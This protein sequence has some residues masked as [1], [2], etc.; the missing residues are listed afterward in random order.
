MKYDLSPA[1][2]KVVAANLHGYSGSDIVSVC[3]SAAIQPL[4]QAIEDHFDSELHTDETDVVDQL[5]T[6]DVRYRFSIV[7]CFDLFL[8][9]LS[10]VSN[11]LLI[12]PGESSHD[13]PL[14]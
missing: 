7:H 6:K 11:T 3:R 2:I 9:I 4:R 14:H 8:S 1:D 5:N 10:H 13:A 12:L